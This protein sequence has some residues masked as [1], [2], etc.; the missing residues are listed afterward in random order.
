M[1]VGP[2]VAVRSGLSLSTL[3]TLVTVA[4]LLLPGTLVGTS[5]ALAAGGRADQ[6]AAAPAQ[7]ASPQNGSTQNGPAKGGPAGSQSEAGRFG[8]RLTEVTDSLRDDPRAREYIIDHLNPESVLRRQ[9]EVY[10]DGTQ[11]L[12]LSLYPAAASIG[13]GEFHFGEGH[14]ANELS[15]WISVNPATIDLGPHDRS[16]AE[17]TID[18]P[19]DASPGEHYAVLWAEAVSAPTQGSGVR[20]VNRVGIRV[21]LDV[22][23]GGPPAA[24]FAISALTASRTPDGRAALSTEVHNTGGRALDMSGD[25]R[26]ERGPGGLQ[27]GPFPANLGTTIGPG[28]IVPVS[29]P[30]DSELP[31]GPWHASVTLRSGL[32]EHTVNATIT[33]PK[34]PGESHRYL[35][36]GYSAW[37]YVAGAGIAVLLLIIV[38]G[39]V[40][41]SRRRGNRRGGRHLATVGSVPSQGNATERQGGASERQDGATERDAGAG[42]ADSGQGGPGDQGAQT[43]V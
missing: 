36:G 10:N 40:L 41:L 21:Y 42:R 4:A 30:L 18:V 24:G 7:G 13:D 31:L 2:R 32:V 9:V 26:L 3:G 11:P 8:I 16:N 35:I 12:H 14:A 39:L 25:L 19:K 27:A 33:F 43:S 29:I 37:H 1:R 28:E 6:A 22:G 38:M 17:V 20:M 34:K 23:P 5:P 15:T